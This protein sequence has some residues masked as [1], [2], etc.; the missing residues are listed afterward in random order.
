MLL[1]ITWLFFAL[2]I[3]VSASAQA[4]GAALR[5][6]LAGQADAWRGI[7]RVEVVEDAAWEVD[8]PN[9]V[10]RSHVTTRYTGAPDGERWQREV[11][12]VEID[13]RPVNVERWERMEQR[14]RR[15][16]G[17]PMERL[18]QGVRLTPPLL[19]Q[20]RPLSPPAPC[21]LAGR[22]CW[23]IDLTPRREGLPI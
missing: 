21:L 6:W 15:L 11:L 9:G 5:A 8:G 10:Q 17:R 2:I 1:R 14:R 16:F 18:V 12:S 20:L 23:R 4:P 19:R 3:P 13:G 7:E 22:R